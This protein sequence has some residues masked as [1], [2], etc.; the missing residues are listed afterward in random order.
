MADGNTLL[1]W[2]KN[3]TLLKTLDG[4]SDHV[5]GAAKL[6]NGTILSWS[7]D[8]TLCIYGKDGILWENDYNS[9]YYS[10][11]SKWI[12]HVEGT[13]ESHVKPFLRGGGVNSVH[14]KSSDMLQFDTAIWHG[15]RETTCRFL[16]HDGTAVVT[17][18]NGQVCFLKLYNGNKRTLNKLEA[19]RGGG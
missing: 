6:K 12:E 16:F 14:L 5:Y 15:E 2:D 3:G 7:N 11:Y 8:Y 4:N 1:L 17:Q 10:V 9:V 19:K 18:A 13:E